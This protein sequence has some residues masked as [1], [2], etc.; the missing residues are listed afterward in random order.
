MVAL[1]DRPLRPY[2]GQVGFCSPAERP[3]EYET[4]RLGINHAPGHNHA[5]LSSKLLMTIAVRVDKRERIGMN[6]IRTASIH[7]IQKDEPVSN[8]MYSYI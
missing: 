7:M 2:P 6:D 5:G 1:T 3:V 4:E 8:D